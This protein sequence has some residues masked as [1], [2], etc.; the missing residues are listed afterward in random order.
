MRFAR[1]GNRREVLLLTP[2][3]PH[4]FGMRPVVVPDTA[5]IVLTI[6]AR[7]GEAMLSVDNRTYRISDGDRIEISRASERILLAVPH[8]ISFY[9]TLH[10]KMMW[11]ADIR[12]R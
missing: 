11:D 3:A 5:R 9:E 2:L 12:N 1:R 10:S 7:R 4:N 6:H 8:N